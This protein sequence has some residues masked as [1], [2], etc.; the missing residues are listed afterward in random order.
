MIPNQWYAI[1]ES[2]EIKP[3]GMKGL[4][5]M[6]Q[7]L[8]LWRNAGGKLS[9]MLDLCPHRGA[10]LSGGQIQGDCIE[11]PFHGFQFDVTGQGQFIPANGKN[12]PVP[13]VFRAQTF[14]VQEAHG[15]VWFWNGEPRDD[16]PPVPWFEELDES[17]EY[18]SIAVRWE[19]H[20]TRSIENQLDVSHLPFVHKNSIGRGN[21]TLVNGP[22]VTLENNTIQVWVDNRIDDGTPPTKPTKMPEPKRPA[23]LTFKF[24]NVWQN[25]LADGFRIM[26]AFAPIDDDATMV[27]V[28]SYQRVKHKNALTKFVAN[29]ATSFNKFV[30][31]EDQKVVE[32]Q[33]PKIAGLDIGERFIP[34]DRPIALFLIHRRDLILAAQ[35]GANVAGSQESVAQADAE[36][37][38]SMAQEGDIRP[39]LPYD[40]IRRRDQ[41]RSRQIA[42]N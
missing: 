11:C 12:T 26:A 25:R 10:A 22:Y 37:D 19:S 23:L 29:V 36:I 24:P 41:Q 27:Y 5:R 28:R 17:F 7:D 40:L 21:R 16:Y 33:R 1:A 15:F 6:G 4:R 39:S 34:G 38:W 42:H 9:C 35:E 2:S 3:G 30:L 32:T 18:G 14:V 8:V 20:Y 31:R 13:K